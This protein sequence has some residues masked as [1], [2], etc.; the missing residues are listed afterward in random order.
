MR[1]TILAL[2]LGLLAVST[3]AQ[4]AKVRDFNISSS[5]DRRSLFGATITSSRA[6]LSLIA[7][8]TGVW[9]LYRVRNWLDASPPEEKLLLSG[10]F[11]N[12]DRHDLETLTAQILVTTD[13]A[14]AICVGSAEWLKRVRGWAVGNANSD[15]VI[16]VVDL[17]TFKVITSTRTKDLGLLESHGV[18]LDQE[19][20]VLVDSL[21]SGKQKTGAFIQLDIPSL[22]AGPRCSYS[23]TVDSSYKQ[24]PVPLTE[25]ECRDALKSLSIEQ[26]L[27][28]QE[29][30]SVR[31][32]PPCENSNS[33]FCRLSSEL[34]PDG[35]FALGYYSTGHDN[36]WGSWVTTEAKYVIFSVAKG[37]EVG[38]IKIS[39]NESTAKLQAS[40][41]GRD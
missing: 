14:Y 24:H 35:K 23:W 39:P 29:P 6:V 5:Q 15:D 21:S 3:A 34:T 9:Q 8:D 38:E 28:E 4:V 26:Y 40:V 18:R 17:K 36:F 11:S 30:K 7:N 33:D 12:Q 10:F 31:D 37:R 25:G 1:W 32:W 16:S 27:Q 13:G 22:K 2:M 41:E 20:H 19:G